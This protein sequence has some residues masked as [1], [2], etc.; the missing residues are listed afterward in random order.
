MPRLKGVIFSGGPFS[1]YEEGAPHVH[2]S[3]WEFL[4]RTRVPVLGV[5]YGLQEMTH[6]L[7]GTVERAEKREFGHALVA[8]AGAVPAGM[9]DILE[10]MS[11]EFKVWMSHGDKL[12][13]LA[14][15]FTIIGSS[16]NCEGAMVAGIVE[17]IPMYGVQFHPGE[18]QK[19]AGIRQSGLPPPRFV[20]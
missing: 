16:D 7:G 15:G 8:R 12:V 13:K 17:G 10:G 2:A 6:A 20:G 19:N 9:A 14:P 3:V 4:K 5:C 11:S 1:V 18:Q